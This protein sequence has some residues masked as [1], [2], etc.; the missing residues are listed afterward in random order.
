MTPESRSAPPEELARPDYEQSV[1]LKGRDH[2]QIAGD[3][4]TAEEFAGAYDFLDS[5]TTFLTTDRGQNLRQPNDF[6]F[7]TSHAI[8]SPTDNTG[9]EQSPAPSPLLRLDSRHG[10]TDDSI[11]TNQHPQQSN[12]ARVFLVDDTLFIKCYKVKRLLLRSGG[13]KTR[14]DVF[15]T[16]NRFDNVQRHARCANKWVRFWNNN[17][18]LAYSLESEGSFNHFHFLTGGYNGKIA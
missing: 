12:C 9:R 3:P 10:S 5:I 6:S 4:D 15:R 16:G 8:L 2:I 13:P 14:Q 18:Q 17:F 7:Q 11:D 1:W